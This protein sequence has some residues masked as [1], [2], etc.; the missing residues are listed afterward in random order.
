MAG[1]TLQQHIAHTVSFNIKIILN[2]TYLAIIGLLVFLSSYSQTSVLSKID[3]ELAATFKAMKDA[4]YQ[5]RSESLAPLFKKEL[6]EQ[7]KNPITFD[8]S[9]DNL[10]KYLTIKTS[11]DKKIKFYSWDDLTGGTWHMINCLA[12]FQSNRGKIIV[13]QLNS[14]NEAEIG[15]YTDSKVYEIHE[16][17]VDNKTH[18][19]TFA[20][21][22]H[23]FGN[24]HQIIQVFTISPNKLVKC[25][26]CLPNNSDLVIE[27]PR[28]EESKLYFNPKSN[29][30]SYCEFTYD[31]DLGYY[32]STGN[33]ITLKLI[34]GSFKK[35]N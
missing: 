2:R 6:Q 25:T 34:N 7:L 19:L 1:E 13:Q 17:I 12:Q 28:S 14:G 11:P 10:S 33:S 3:N 20:W 5:L 22:T 24:Q 26:S 29:E 8:N 15:G 35:Y 18:Y 30:I 27:Y 4:D 23:G 9:L 31:D 32:R 21:G 16:I